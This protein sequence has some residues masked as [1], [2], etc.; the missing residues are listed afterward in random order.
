MADAIQWILVPKGLKILHYLDDFIFVSDSF[1]E[2]DFQKQLL[3]DTFKNLGVPLE[4]SKLEGP[5]TCL[6][7]LGIE[8]DTMT[9]QIRLPPQKLSNLKSEFSQAVS[10]QREIYKAWWVC[11]NMLQK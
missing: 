7:F 10:R 1:E 8:F 9:L 5:A 4:T 3:I 6:T 2:A 11:F